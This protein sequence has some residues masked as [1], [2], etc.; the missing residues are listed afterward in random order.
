MKKDQKRGNVYVQYAHKTS[1]N[2][3]NKEQNT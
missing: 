2:R 3:K 1:R